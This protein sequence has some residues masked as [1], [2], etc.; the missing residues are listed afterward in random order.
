[1]TVIR[2]TGGPLANKLAGELKQEILD[3]RIAP[4]QF[5]PSVRQ[6][7][8]SRQ[9]A[10]KTVHQAVR[11]LAGDGLVSAEVGRGYRVLSRANDPTRGCPIACVK[12]SQAPG[13]TW[14]GFGATL[15]AALQAAAATQGWSLL[16]VGA[17]G[18]AAEQLIE[19][20]RQARSWALIVDCYDPRV[21]ELAAKAGLP[22]IMVDSWH[23]EARADAVL[24][25]GF[26]GGYLAA[27]HLAAKGHRRIGWVGQITETAHGMT[28]FGGA[29]N[30]LRESGLAFEADDILE[31]PE[32]TPSDAVRRFLD[33]PERPTAVLALWQRRCVETVAAVRALGLVPGRDVEV[34]GWC[35]EEEYAGGYAGAFQD[36]QVPPTVTW[37]VA[38]LA[39]TAVARLAERRGR[40]DLPPVRIN[41]ETRLV[42]RQA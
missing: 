22:S 24:Q 19:Q 5:L 30:G 9:M 21:L 2:T 13:E 38:T 27:R 23:P 10:P 40:P 16:G 12:S 36:A 18:M 6:L 26:L 41:V 15:L 25:D 3:G 8:H 17:Q 32:G 28:R 39:R 4:G 42:A 31:L 1:M 33:R 35:S 34:V 20:C 29:V 7:S 14:R 37:S 11:S